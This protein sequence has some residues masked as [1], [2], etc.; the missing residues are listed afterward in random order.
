M[1]CHAS[2][3]MFPED[4]TQHKTSQSGL[5]IQHHAQ[6]FGIRLGHETLSDPRLIVPVLLAFGTIVW[7]ED[8][9]AMHPK[10]RG[11]PTWPWYQF[12]QTVLVF[13]VILDLLQHAAFIICPDV[14]PGM[15]D[16]DEAH[17]PEMENTGINPADTTPCRSAFKLWLEERENL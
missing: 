6:S 13:I 2:R 7:F 9:N 16:A 14:A 1:T 5:V 12:F 8:T 4:H 10:I 3:I 15:E 17:Y 11:I